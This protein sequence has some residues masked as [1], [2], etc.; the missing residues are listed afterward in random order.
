MFYAVISTARNASN[1]SKYYA[2]PVAFLARAD[3]SAWVE[4][5]NGVA[6]TARNAVKNCGADALSEARDNA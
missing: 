1:T 5:N 6:L 2:R 4:S 3:R